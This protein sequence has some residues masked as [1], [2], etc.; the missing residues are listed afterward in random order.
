MFPAGFGLYAAAMNIKVIL[1]RAFLLGWTIVCAIFL[2]GV[3]MKT[4]QM[5]I[6][7]LLLGI[8]ISLGIWVAGICAVWGAAWL[9]A[10]LLGISQGALPPT[11]H[12]AP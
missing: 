7:D 3:V 1:W 12:N 11:D 8:G 4:Y 9:V 2:Y 10:R 6:S 5:D